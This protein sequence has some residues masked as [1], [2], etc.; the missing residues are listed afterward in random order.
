MQ[1]SKAAYKPELLTEKPWQS[2]QHSP[3]TTIAEVEEASED[4]VKKLVEAVGVL[5]CKRMKIET[6]DVQ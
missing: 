5:S 1:T 6:D 3:S 4:V 2:P